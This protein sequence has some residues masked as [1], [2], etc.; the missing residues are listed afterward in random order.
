MKEENKGS[1]SKPASVKVGCKV[2]AKQPS[3]RVEVKISPPPKPS[4]IK[5]EDQVRIKEE[6]KHTPERTISDSLIGKRSTGTP[7]FRDLAISQAIKPSHES[8]TPGPGP[9]LHMPVTWRILNAIN[10]YTL[11][12]RKSFDELY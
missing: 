5:K 11:L 8:S 10:E 7:N 3:T 2:K 12:K 1:A 9:A 6:V 4:S